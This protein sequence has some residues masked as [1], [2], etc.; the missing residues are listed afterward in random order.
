MTK[1]SMD[2][3]VKVLSKHIKKIQS[4]IDQRLPGINNEIDFIV[5]NKEQF[6]RR[7]EGLLDE[8]L[9]YLSHGRGKEEF[10]R[11]NKYYASIDKE[12]ASDY[13]R[14]YRDIMTGK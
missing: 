4:L 10:K 13:S 12:A 7:I 5:Q 3:L 8:L 9:G 11:L 6:P 2:D 14:Y 1:Q